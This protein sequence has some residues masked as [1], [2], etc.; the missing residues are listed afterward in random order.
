ML[1]LQVVTEK[2]TWMFF[3]LC[4]LRP[5]VLGGTSGAQGLWKEGHG[6]STLL[7]EHFCLEMFYTLRLLVKCCQ[8]QDFIYFK[9]TK[10]NNKKHC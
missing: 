9:Q 3:R 8:K 4:L 7:L 10:S 2:S 1:E 5:C 6:Q